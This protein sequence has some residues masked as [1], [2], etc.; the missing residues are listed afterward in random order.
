MKLQVGL[1]YFQGRPAT[2]GDLSRLL[3]EFAHVPAETQG[4]IRDDSILMVYRGDRLTCEEDFEVQPLQQGPYLLTWDGRLDNREDFAVCLPDSNLASVPDPAIVLQAYRMFGEL[5]FEKLIG[6]FALTLWNKETRSLR[7]VRSGCGARTLYY[8]LTKEALTWSSDFAH[9]VRVS[10]VDLKVNDE[11]VRDYF[12]SEPDTKQT[13]LAAIQAVPPNRVLTFEN[14]RVRRTQEL[15]DPT[16]ISPLRYHRDEEYEEDCRQR[17]KEAVRTRLRSKYPV[18]AELSGGLDSSTIVLTA[19]EILR[20][21]NQSTHNLQTVSCIYEQSGTCDE[22][23]FIFAVTSKRGIDTHLVHEQDQRVTLGLEDDP[24]FTGLPNPLYCLPGRYETIAKFMR[25]YQARVLLTGNG[26][27]HLFWSEPDGAPIVADQLRVGNFIRAHRECRTWSR[28]ACMPYYELLAAKALPLALRSVFPGDSLYKRPDMPKWLRGESRGNSLSPRVDFDKYSGWRSS[29]SH[30]AQI[31]LVDRIFR[32]LGWGVFNECSQ[33]YVSHPYSYRP[34]I[35]F[36][37]A[38]PISQFLRNGQTRSLMRRA[39]G[40][41]LP[42]KVARRVSKGLFDETILRAL[43]RERQDG[44]DAKNWQVC[45]RGYVTFADLETELNQARMGLLKLS[46]P[47]LRLFSMERW[48]RSLSHA[49]DHA[50]RHC[51]E[52]VAANFSNFAAAPRQPKFVS[53]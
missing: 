5:V 34:L 36:C 14:R 31:F 3:G 47:L 22:R 43:Q 42:S 53:G 9:L 40:G 7:F 32:L 28:V 44:T 35:E 48:L 39:F 33:V 21:R 10:G 11:Y 15:W 49:R 52:Q 24:P 41:M 20:E 12:V 16:R 8:A 18:F 45:Q 38:A 27:D 1:F 6:E 13:P 25:Q 46:G 23:G 37:L 51:P 30:R 19:D 26:G 50:P 29:P 4:A 2:A 17:M